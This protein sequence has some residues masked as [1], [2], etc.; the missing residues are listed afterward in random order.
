MEKKET[1]KL[2]I[3]HRGPL[4]NKELPIILF[5]SEKAGCT[6]FTKWFFFQIGLLEE[7]IKQS[8]HVYRIQMYNQQKNYFKNLSEQILN[9]KKEAIKLVRNPYNRAVSS[10]LTISHYCFSSHP[11]NNRMYKDWERIYKLFYNSN[12]IYKGISFKQFLYYLE[13]VGSDISIVD[14]HIGQQYLDGEENLI[15][16]YI[17]LEKLQ[18]EIQNIEKKYSLPS[19]PKSIFAQENDHNFS[20]SMIEKG[21]IS[22]E[23]FTREMLFGNSLPTFESFYDKETLELCKSIFKKDFEVYGYSF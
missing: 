2:F 22:D 9:S 21:N 6:S 10:F 11:I 19:C 20:K 15:T 14:G 13:K 8:V 1:L 5:W 17:K 16:R 18:G 12:S 23:V 3:E 7:A 4:C